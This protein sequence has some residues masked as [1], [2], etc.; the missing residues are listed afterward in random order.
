MTTYSNRLPFT[1]ERRPGRPMAPRSRHT[2]IRP[3]QGVVTRDGTRLMI[4]FSRGGHIPFINAVKSI[5]GWRWHPVVDKPS[6]GGYWTV[7]V[8]QIRE[9]RAAAARHGWHLSAGVNALPDMAPGD[10]ALLVTVEGEQLVIDGPWRQ[11]INELLHAADG[12]LDESG[13]WRLPLEHCVD[14]VLDMRAI[15]KVRFVGNATE[16]TDRIDR[17]T[18]MLTLSRQLTK[19]PGWEI[20][21][22]IARNIDARE[23]QHSGIEYAWRSPRTFN[24]AT[25]GAGK[26]TIALCAI[27]QLDWTAGDG[28]PWALDFLARTQRAGSTIVPPP[29]TSPYPLLVVCP[30]GLKTNWLREVHASVPHRTVWVCEGMVPT[31]PLW[32]PDVWVVNYDVLGLPDVGKPKRRS[33]VTHFTDMMGRGEI[34]SYIIDEGHRVNN[35]KAQR[36]VAVLEASRALAVDAPRILL[37]GTPLRN[38]RRKELVPQLGAIGREGEFGDT[39]QLKEDERLSRR[40]RTVCAWR[41]N[42]KAVLQALGVIGPDG[43]A[44]PIWQPL[45]IDGDPKILVEYR[46]A[47]DNFME[48]LRDK[49]RAKAIELG[50]D[51]ESAAVAAAM[52][53]GSAEALMLV[54]TLCRLAGQAK[55]KAAKEWVADFETTGDK[56]VV[57]AENIDMMDAISAGRIP[58]IRG[59]V[60]HAKRNKL[61]DAFQNEAWVPEPDR[62]QTLV[63]QIV[64]A[65][66]GITLTEA[67]QMLFAQIV[68]TPGAMDQAASRA[69]WRMNDPHNVICHVLVCAD[70]IDEDR[71]TVLDAKRKQMALV[72]DG[73]ERAAM[74]QEST[75]GDVFAKMLNR[76]LGIKKP[77]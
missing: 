74:A 44:E 37:T 28:R 3:V 16:I 73:D 34:N 21:P 67:Y 18:Y 11:D 27:E 14:V 35:P 51:P 77:E 66:E 20:S 76:A 41:P 24:W 31:R 60:S 17:A 26:T 32:T 75:Y 13:T 49:A 4:R 50:E 64:A 52:R 6:E 72:T 48:Y 8:G 70:T 42:P 30:A 46:R 23:F 45:V 57:F 71:M 58:Q 39:K 5:K 12:R 9:V 10:V 38:G 15:A 47:E 7:H 65:G 40:L 29:E 59:R 22:R 68:W 25:M 19:T 43:K 62:I 1:G 53:A 36:T 56:L 55:I 63:C 69:A 61:V 33:W 54:N 2:D